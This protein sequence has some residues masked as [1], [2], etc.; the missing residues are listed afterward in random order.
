MGAYPS[1][2][3]SPR[4]DT[5]QD[6]DRLPADY[7]GG[8]WTNEVQMISPAVKNRFITFDQ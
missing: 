6:L 4:L 7:H 3:I 1:W 2:N 5:R 8:I